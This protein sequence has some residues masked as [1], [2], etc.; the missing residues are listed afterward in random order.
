[1]TK[2]VNLL[3]VMILGISVMSFSQSVS[4]EFTATKKAT[5]NHVNSKYNV[6]LSQL[7]QS[8][9][10]IKFDGKKLSMIFTSG[11]NYWV[12]DI[13]SYKIDENDDMFKIYIIKIKDG[14]DIIEA[15]LSKGQKYSIELP[16]YVKGK[17]FSSDFFFE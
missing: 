8:D 5:V 14:A 4:I 10:N 2:K 15:K 17:L 3:L 16:T 1:M 11:K 7:P 9:L 13:I 6:P 12:T